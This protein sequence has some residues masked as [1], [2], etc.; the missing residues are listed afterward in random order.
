M[1]EPLG[2]SINDFDAIFLATLSSYGELRG[3]IAH[4]SIKHTQQSFDKYDEY[5]KIDK[6]LKGIVQFE[7]VI[8]SIQ[9]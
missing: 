8:D 6:I 5:D 1:Y 2:Y 3:E 7:E 9:N 4:S